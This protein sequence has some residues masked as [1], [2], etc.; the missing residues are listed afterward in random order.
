MDRGAAVQL[1]EEALA[2]LTIAEV[3]SSGSWYAVTFT[4]PESAGCR[5]L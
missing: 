3:S 2:C 5:V 4:V 1:Q